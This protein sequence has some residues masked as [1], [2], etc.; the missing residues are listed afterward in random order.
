MTSSNIPADGDKAGST[1]TCMTP[2]QSGAECLVAANMLADKFAEQA[3]ERDL[4]RQ[5]PFAEFDMIRAQGI[6][7]IRV[8]KAMGGPGGSVRELAEMTRVISKADPNIGQA[9]TPHLIAADSAILWGTPAQQKNI[10]DARLSGEII[11]NA[12]AERGGTFMNTRNTR[13]TADGD[14][15]RLEGK[16]FYSTGALMAD[17]IFATAMMEDGVVAL[18]FV[19]CKREGLVLI[20]DWEGMGQRTTASGTTVFNNVRLERDEVMPL[21]NFRTERTYFATLAQLLH[22]AVDTGIAEAALDDA[23]DFVSTKA[24]AMPESGVER[25][26]DDPYVISTIGQMTVFTHQAEAML[27]R[28]ADFLEPMVAAQ[29]AGTL[30]GEELEAG[31]VEASIAVAEAKIVATE[32]SLR[33]SEMLYNVAGASATLRKYN[34]DRHWRNARTHTTHDPISYKY[35]HVGNYHLSRTPP[36]ISTKI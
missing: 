14:G 24:R 29:Q 19:P 35:K 30:G 5:L 26:I 8:P 7:A 34:F 16:K 3:S 25:Q 22:A 23:I 17:Q 32:S 12:F 36:P 9:L 28:A 11:N 27:S 18:V 13:L 15:Y 21:P 10:C 2:P 6:H 31:L 33:V 4:D 1:T 20:D